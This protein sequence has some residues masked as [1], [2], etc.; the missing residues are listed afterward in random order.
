MLN[1]EEVAAITDILVTLMLK[2]QAPFSIRFSELLEKINH[3]EPCGVY[4]K[5]RIRSS[6]IRFGLMVSYVDSYHEEYFDFLYVMALPHTT[7]LYPI[8][9]RRRK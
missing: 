5:I 1:T 9:K 8:K 3:T 4:D 2:S 6:A 7:I